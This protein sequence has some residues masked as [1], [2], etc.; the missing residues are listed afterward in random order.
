MALARSLAVLP[1]N[2]VYLLPPADV[3]S[4]TIAIACSFALSNAGFF[5]F[6]M[7]PPVT[8]GKNQNV[9]LPKEVNFHCNF[10]LSAALTFLLYV[11][12]TLSSQVAHF[13]I[14]LASSATSVEWILECGDKLTKLADSTN[15][16][17]SRMLFTVIFLLTALAAAGI[18]LSTGLARAL[19]DAGLDFKPVVLIFGL[20]N[21]MKSALCIIALK[22]LFSEGQALTEKY[23]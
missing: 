17:L 6:C 18:Y 2:F 23:R 13:E 21:V 22:A 4:G 19:H 15:A 10:Q 9:F 20:A 3:S 5:T 12:A 14:M 16:L 7:A 1:G 11:L 8:T